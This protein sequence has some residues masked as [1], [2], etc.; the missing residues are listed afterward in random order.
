MHL[1]VINPHF[2]RGSV[3]RRGDKEKDKKK[4]QKKE[5]KR[6]CWRP[7][8]RNFGGICINIFADRGDDRLCVGMMWYFGRAAG[9]GSRGTFACSL[10]YG[11]SWC[12]RPFTC[13]LAC[14]RAFRFF[15]CL[16][17][18]ACLITRLCVLLL[19]SLVVRSLVYVLAPVSSLLFVC[20]LVVLVCSLGYSFIRCLA[21]LFAVPLLAYLHASLFPSLFVPFLTFRCTLVFA[22]ATSHACLLLFS[23]ACHSLACPFAC[24]LACVHFFACMPP[25]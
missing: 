4:R 6:K 16:L 23:L 19:A 25:V 20:S 14:L 22:L 10:V 8:L 21:C 11:F 2:G 5:K 24:L 9:I 12:R 13:L 18:L 17:S 3:S 15:V 1:A 7:G